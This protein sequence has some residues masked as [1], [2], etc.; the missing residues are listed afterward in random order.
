M[1]IQHRNRVWIVPLFI[2]WCFD[3]LFWKRTPGISFFIFVVLC[4]AGGLLLALWEKRKPAPRTLW[5]LLPVL[6]FSAM[7]FIR[8]EAGT[9]FFNFILTQGFMVILAMTFLSGL[10]LQYSLRDYIAGFFRLAGNT[11]ARP[12]MHF[13][14]RPG[15]PPADLPAEQPAKPTVRPLPV[16]RGLLLAVPIVAV[17][18]I[19]LASADPVF[20]TGLVQFLSFLNLDNLGE[21][22][23]RAIYIS[24]GA[25]LLMGVYL[26][27][28][29]V[30]QHS[31]LI[32]I[33]KPDDVRF[34]GWTEAAVVLLLVDL[35]FAV[36]VGIQFRYFFGGQAN[37]AVQSFTYADYA[38]R[39]FFELVLVAVLS[40]LLWMGLSTVARRESTNQR[41]IFSGLGV[42]LVLLVGVM[43]VS[44]FQRLLLYESAYG[45][46]RLRAY[47]HVFMICLGLLL[48]AAVVLE[49]LQRQR[50]F[51]LSILVA[52]LGFGVS[53]NLLNVDGFIVQQNLGRAQSGGILDAGYLATLSNDSVP[54]L[55][56]SFHATGLRVD[57]KD[58][59]GGI[60]ACR[61]AFD[62]QERHDPSWQSFNAAR[63]VAQDLYSR[64]QGEL[65][66]Y[67]VKLGDDG[68]VV[69]FG[70]SQRQ[71]FGFRGYD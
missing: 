64:Y 47:T 1:D 19:L 14:R 66:A 46:S 27:A 9:N 59:V 37:I 62:Q 16:L 50:A 41:R 55:F 13:A 24:I 61:A 22:I 15:N 69:T 34:L 48:L 7:T 11:L 2:A 54:V 52:A 12:V 45:F 20:N 63:S 70:G 53:L 68:W 25:Y 43:L 18:A 58:E 36:F 40:L 4:L 51:V 29:Q 26:H 56:D 49:L 39:G 8:Q 71:C 3:F 31:K 38:R 35:L 10:W 33:E 30:S 57:L 21:Y 5:L 42:A 28:L 65:A 6:F 32:G 23:F 67:P 17:M 60:L 44:A